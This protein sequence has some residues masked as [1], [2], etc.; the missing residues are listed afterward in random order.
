MEQS[1]T[2]YPFGIKNV[3]FTDNVLTMTLGTQQS[4]KSLSQLPMTMQGAG[5]IT[6]MMSSPANNVIKVV[7]RA[8]K[9]KEKADGA[10]IKTRDSGN[11]IISETD[12]YISFKSGMTEA[13]ITKTPVPQITYY[14]GESVI[15]SHAAVPGGVYIKESFDRR[16][17]QFSCGVILN[18]QAGEKYM[19]FGGG[20]SAVANGRKIMTDPALTVPGKTNTPFFVSSANYGIFVNTIGNVT[21]DCA[22]EG[23]GMK[24]ETSGSVLEFELFA[25]NSVSDII[26]TY[27]GFMGRAQHVSASSICTAIAMQDDFTITPDEILNAIRNISDTGLNISEVW[28][29]RS[30]LPAGSPAGFEW[31]SK[32]FPDVQSFL[33]SAHDLGVRIGITVTPYI[34]EE[35]DL[36]DELTDLNN[37]MKDSRGNTVI[38]DTQEGSVAVIDMTNVAARNWFSMKVGEFIDAGID[39]VEGAFD[40]NLIGN[41]GIGGQDTGKEDGFNS[42]FV[43]EFN[44][45]IKDASSRA[46]GKEISFM[47][48]NIVS[49]GD[50]SVAYRNISPSSSEMNFGGMSAAISN[51]LS[52]GLSGFT[53]INVD[54]PY[55]SD[56]NLFRRWLEAAL[57]APHSR[58]MC[59]LKGMPSN[60]P[61]EAFE[62]IKLFSDMRASLAPYIYSA[63]MEA[64]MYGNP[65]LRTMSYE[66]PQDALAS[67]AQDQF[68]VG[69]SILSAPVT[70]SAGSVR[71]YVPAGVWTNLFSRETLTGPRFATRKEEPGSFP[72]FVR[73]NSIITTLSN[74]D[75]HSSSHSFLDN[76]TFTCFAPVD[77]KVAACE[78]F[79]DKGK[80]SGVINV[81]KE[82]NKITVK[83]DGFGRNKRIALT[84]I[85]NVVSVSESIPEPENWGT[86]VDFAG[87]ELIITL[88]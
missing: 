51:A 68:M 48:A 79:D 67:F 40:F 33:R 86:S 38:I 45:A 43:S 59:N 39:M 88:G 69:S 46:K 56:M 5:N 15:T 19:G 83:T 8:H 7:L 22:S 30:Y 52:Y 85:T 31:D 81:L 13:R 62:Q 3:S 74:P 24:F 58:I 35:S 26:N 20:V 82:G 21:F 54:V 44:G 23:N 55:V 25:G 50:L 78:V 76:I 66:F 80:A 87:N 14:Y 18:A 75:S 71:F 29:G 12:D 1:V 41:I 42:V 28:L 49:T 65:A 84:G 72:L 77:G 37:L 63:V 10:F 4:A 6:L 47:I 61:K 36:F 9:R 2:R 27:T 34:F 57:L 60:L 17:D 32:R 64:S 73:P 11:G 16:K 70:S 53:L